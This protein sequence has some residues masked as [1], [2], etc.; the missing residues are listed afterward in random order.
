MQK[1]DV[2]AHTC[3]I[4][5]YGD[6]A[7]ARYAPWPAGVIGKLQANGEHCFPIRGGRRKGEREER[8]GKGKNG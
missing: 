5:C 7:V 2:M 8:K 4:Q 6:G 3:E 1:S